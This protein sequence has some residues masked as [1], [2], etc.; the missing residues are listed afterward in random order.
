MTLLGI[1]TWSGHRPVVKNELQF[2]HQYLGKRTSSLRY[3]ESTRPQRT[4]PVAVGDLHQRTSTQ[5]SVSCALCS[6]VKG[7]WEVGQVGG[8]AGS[9]HGV[10]RAQWGGERARGRA[11]PASPL[12]LRGLPVVRRAQG[13]GLGFGAGCEVLAVKGK[14]SGSC[15]GLR[16]VR[17]PAQGPGERGPWSSKA[18]RRNQLSA[19]ELPIS[20]HSGTGEG[21]GWGGGHLFRTG[22][23]M[24]VSEMQDRSAGPAKARSRALE[25]LMVANNQPSI[26]GLPQG[27]LLASIR[28]GSGVLVPNPLPMPLSDRTTQGTKVVAFH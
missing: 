21:G 24:K 25:P 26:G 22:Q 18:R 8:G 2:E 3:P 15:W 6:N 20:S 12:L 16:V 10:Q 11:G 14:R 9:W 4:R 1:I 5:A 17:E 23:L 7:W 28:K 13:P 27:W 19:S